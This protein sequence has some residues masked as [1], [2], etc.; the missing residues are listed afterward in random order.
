MKEKIINIPN[1]IT[2]LRLLLLPAVLILF[3][4][5]FWVAAAALYIILMLSDALDG[6]AARKLKQ[7]TY[8]G[9]CFDTVADF[10]VYYTFLI[11]LFMNGWIVLVNFILIMI[12]AIPLIG[13]IHTISRKAGRFYTPHKI[14]A[15]VFAIA[16]HIALLS[17]LIRYFYA[18]YVLFAALVVAYVYTIPDY[19]RYAMKYR[20]RRKRKKK[21][22]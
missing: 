4:R 13:I 19:L 14:S 5:E 12:S 8:F 2:F 20:P 10:G 18:N 1:A 11:Y 6:F 3:H 9:R 7:E 17:F 15:K 22:K 16:I 21:K